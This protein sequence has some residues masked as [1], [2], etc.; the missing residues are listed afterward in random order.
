MKLSKIINFLSTSR[1]P[2]QKDVF[3]L[4]MAIVHVMFQL[5]IS[6]LTDNYLTIIRKFVSL[7]DP[8]KDAKEALEIAKRYL[9]H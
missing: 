4:G 9:K 8:V 5:N 3:M 7:V 2:F 6:I 1:W